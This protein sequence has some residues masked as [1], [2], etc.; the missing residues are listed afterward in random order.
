MESQ[1][2]S[3]GE[4]E[5][6]IDE[7]FDGIKKG[8]Q[9]YPEY[10]T[11]I[12]KNKFNVSNKDASRAGI[13][14]GY[15]TD[16][17]SLANANSG[18]QWDALNT[19]KAI[20][21]G[22]DI[23]RDQIKN[24]VHSEV[25]IEI[26]Y[27]VANEDFTQAAHDK[28]AEAQKKTLLSEI[29]QYVTEMPESALATADKE[30]NVAEQVFGEASTQA[31]NARTTKAAINELSDGRMPSAADIEIL[32]K[33]VSFV[34]ILHNNQ[35]LQS[36]K[37]LKAIESQAER[38]LI[39]GVA[40]GKNAAIADI[41]SYNQIQHPNL[42]RFAAVQ[43]AENCT[44][45][46]EYQATFT[47]N[48]R[49]ALDEITR[50]NRKN[51]EMADEKEKRK[52]AEFA[53]GN[54]PPRFAH[55]EKSIGIQN[56]A[57]SLDYSAMFTQEAI[58]HMGDSV[59]A[60][61]FE[62]HDKIRIDAGGIISK[63]VETLTPEQRQS[64]NQKEAERVLFDGLKEVM[65]EHGTTD[66]P[67]ETAAEQR[68]DSPAEFSKENQPVATE[69]S[70]SKLFALADVSGEEYFAAR[71]H[72]GTRVSE[73]TARAN[74][75]PYKGEVLE[76]ESHLVQLVSSKSI[77]F[78]RKSDVTLPDGLQKVNGH[79]LSI[80]YKGITANA[81]P[82]DPVKDQLDR[83]VASLDRAAKAIGLPESFGEQLGKARNEAWK[84]IQASR[85][86][87]RETKEPTQEQDAPMRSPSR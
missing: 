40:P 10:A 28:F 39:E 54:P 43:I 56:P 49:G 26:A 73:Y 34:D 16:D 22:E 66:F 50:L 7:L 84:G 75:G 85:N 45:S 76:T 19:V 74:G 60:A 65:K 44:Q 14:F 32:V 27:Q 36:E 21:N 5:S 41:R 20:I 12:A 37:A 69:P 23:S 64:F 53:Q 70:H 63:F 55:E 48:A 51:A 58:D 42:K 52:V 33:S 61:I 8:I 77:V 46:P 62:D 1:K 57:N 81:Y 87:I 18:N 17:Y 24:L 31:F 30:I 4:I 82:L 25:G 6:R 13:L 47:A 68:I 15:D 79:E 67:Y 11:L 80:Y 71:S 72:F 35:I 29:Q 3:H 59:N 86:P 83:S 9:E 38:F 2:M 78:H